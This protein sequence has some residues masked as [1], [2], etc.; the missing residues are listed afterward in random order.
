MKEKDFNKY[1]KNAKYQ[2]EGTMTIS[3][4]G[5]KLDA[6]TEPKRQNKPVC[7]TGKKENSLT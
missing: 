6:I 2:G 4:N 1:Q 3:G 5:L 7:G